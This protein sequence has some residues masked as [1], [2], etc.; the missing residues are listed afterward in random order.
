VA[1]GIGEGLEG[2]VE[3]IGYLVVRFINCLVEKQLSN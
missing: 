1:C 3:L 2:G